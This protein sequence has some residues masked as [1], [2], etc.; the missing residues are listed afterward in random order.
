MSN[1][2]EMRDKTDELGIALRKKAALDKEIAA[3]KKAIVAYAAKSKV[4][5]IVGDQYSV[6]V[7]LVDVAEYDPSD[8]LSYLDSIG[9]EQKASLRSFFSVRNG[10]LVKEFGT[11]IKDHVPVYAKKRKRISCTKLNRL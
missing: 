2:T 4:D 10:P 5:R 9:W 8:L 1:I 6:A 11:S 3:L 7:S